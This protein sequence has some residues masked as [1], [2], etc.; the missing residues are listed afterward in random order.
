MKVVLQ[1]LCISLAISGC[2][3]VET[4][5]GEPRET[6]SAP[7]PAAIP[8]GP[9]P[10]TLERLEGATLERLDL[11]GGK[12]AFVAVPVGAREKRAV[13][14]GVHGAGDRA[15]WSCSEWQAVTA[16]WA[17]VVCP[18]GVRHPR[19]PNAL[20]WSSAEAI[21]SAADESVRALRVR[22][23]AWVDDGPLI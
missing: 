7:L 6:T 1:A 17:F 2:A 21:A 13:V 15:D 10:V 12:H 5:R 19:D 23:G 3:R 16:G 14:V 9:E 22:Y 11:A 20:V 8:R 18:E 4:A